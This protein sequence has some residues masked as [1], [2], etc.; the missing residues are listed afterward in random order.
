MI[1]S[2]RSS[3]GYREY[4]SEAV[5]IVKVIR[6]LLHCGF[7]TRQILEVPLC[8]GGRIEGSPEACAASI[9]MHNA[10]LKELDSLIEVLEQRRKNLLDRI[11]L[12]TSRRGQDV[13]RL[14]VNEIA[15]RNSLMHQ[16]LK[17]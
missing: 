11:E 10:K 15:H 5:E 13:P 8:A 9:R 4:H 12:H 1:R 2:E 3:N 7:G 16:R 17:R 6:M 14:E